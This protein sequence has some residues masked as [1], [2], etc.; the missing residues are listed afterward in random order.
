MERQRTTQVI[1]Q[2][3]VTRRDVVRGAGAAFGVAIVGGVFG[4]GGSEQ[5]TAVPASGA[6]PTVPKAKR[7]GTLLL[8][9]NNQFRDL[10]PQVG[11][12]SN[13]SLFVHDRLG[14][15]DQV[16]GRYELSL[17]Q[18]F[19]N[20]DPLT[21]IWKIKPNA[22]FQNLPP[23]NGRNV[24]SGDVVASWN[25]NVANPRATGQA[26]FTD[27][28]DHYETPDPVTLVVKCKKPNA[29]MISPQGLAGPHPTVV[30]PK[31]L[32]DQNVLE[33]VSVGCGPYVLESFDAAS[34]ISFKRRPDGWHEADRPYVDRVAYQ[35]ITDS[36]AR[37]A[38][39]KAKQIDQLAARDK[40]EADEFKGY[41]PDIVID[42][43]LANPAH[44]TARADEQGL[45][46]DVRVREALYNALNIQELIDMVELGEAEW[47]APVPPYLEEWQLPADEIKKAFPHDVAKAKQLL[48]AGGWDSNQEVEFK[49]P[50][51]DKVALL[52]QLIQKQLADVG[53]KTKLV[54]QDALTVW[55]TQTWQKRDYQ[56]TVTMAT[57]T[58]QCPDPW[59]LHFTT[60]DRGAG[61]QAH[62]S[63]PEIDKIVEAQELEFDFEKQRQLILDAQRLIFKKFVPIFVLYTPYQL[64][65]RWAYFHP[66]AATTGYAGTYGHYG[67]VDIDHPGYPK[68]RK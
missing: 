53:I 7:G 14:N 17:A 45:F 50:S 43:A 36:A 41:G 20:P 33:K 52:A 4:C 15:Y 57:W 39:L 32:I 46:R 18:S 63:D 68:D 21:Y 62:F 16:N 49:Y 56:L 28:V 10:N 6:S 8:P 64:T 27:F 51:S 42:R 66:A 19:E 65:G 11:G 59:L 47:G 35:V 48:A 60:N 40:L 3:R 2:K 44:L 58:G 9:Q 22:R 5:K 23:V 34:G 26:I 25:A 54:P 24:T 12:G 29:W 31:E 61:N 38:A 37:S 30:V 67:W 1:W 13:T 55:A